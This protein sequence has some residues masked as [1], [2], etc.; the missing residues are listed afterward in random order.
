[1]EV[2]YRGEWGTV[3]DDSWDINDAKVVCRQLGYK[4]AIGALQGRFV[5][6]GTGRIWLDDVEC[7]GHEQNLSDCRHGG[8]GRHN[9]R[10]YEDAGVEC[11]STGIAIDS[12]II[13]DNFHCKLNFRLLLDSKIKFSI[14]ARLYFRLFRCSF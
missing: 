8:W 4:Y 3:C 5:Q 11:S 9:C 12:I 7:N 2:Y 1:M 10:H 13:T 14:F 6:D